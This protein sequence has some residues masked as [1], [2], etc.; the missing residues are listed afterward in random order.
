MPHT[1]RIACAEPLRTTGY[2]LF[3][4]LSSTDDDSCSTDYSVG[5]VLL[6]SECLEDS[7]GYSTDDDLDSLE[8]ETSSVNVEEESRRDNT[9][10]STC[11][12]Q[13]MLTQVVSP[14]EQ[15]H[16][17]TVTSEKSVSKEHFG[18]VLVM[19][20]IDMNVRRSFQRHDRTTKSYHFCHLYALQN[21]INTSTLSDGPPSGTL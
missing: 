1:Q 10:Q 13:T 17:E 14:E 4:E 16:D 19:D 11:S 21:R 15:L 18:Y 5:D 12:Q 3:P 6:F 2:N 8:Q 9:L 20:N 7:H